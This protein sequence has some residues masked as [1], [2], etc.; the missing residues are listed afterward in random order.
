MDLTG[1]NELDAHLARIHQILSEILNS[2]PTTGSANLEIKLERRFQDNS[3]SL[4]VSMLVPGQSIK[5]A[6]EFDG[7]NGTKAHKVALESALA[8]LIVPITR[9][10]TLI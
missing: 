9:G 10:F 1:N 8:N 7:R 4:T 6:A 3:L 5:T 2:R